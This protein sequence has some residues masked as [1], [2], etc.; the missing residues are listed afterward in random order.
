M[1][2][3]ASPQDGHR[4]TPLAPQAYFR[5]AGQI[6]ASDNNGLVRLRIPLFPLLKFFRGHCARWHDLIQDKDQREGRINPVADQVHSDL[7][8]MLFLQVQKCDEELRRFSSTIRIW[9]PDKDLRDHPL[10]AGHEDGLYGTDHMHFLPRDTQTKRR[11]RQ[12]WEEGSLTWVKH[13]PGGQDTVEA[14][15]ARARN[16]LRPNTFQHHSVRMT[17]TQSG[18]ANSTQP[19]RNGRQAL[20]GAIALGALFVGLQGKIGTLFGSPP[21][22]NHDL[23]VEHDIL[24]VLKIDDKR[25]KDMSN[26][27]SWIHDRVE[28]HTDDLL[29][30]TSTNALATYSDIFYARMQLITSGLRQL[31]HRNLD[32]GLVSPERLRTALWKLNGAMAI[33]GL[34]PIFNSELHLYELDIGHVASV[35]NLEV[36]IEVSVPAEPVNSRAKLFRFLPFPIRP[37]QNSSVWLEPWP[38]YEIIAVSLDGTRYTEIQESTLGRCRNIRGIFLCREAQIWMTFHRPSC[39]SSLF[40]QS[41]STILSA[42]RFAAVHEEERL[43]QVDARTFHLFSK[44]G[45]ILTTRCM[46]SPNKDVRNIQGMV[47]VSL[48][49]GCQAETPSFQFATTATVQQDLAMRH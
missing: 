34:Q 28:Q 18:V 29:T 32:P 41:G 43:I 2:A 47:A 22:A 9:F 7:R 21:R 25:L 31:L 16:R 45:T 14:V 37:S 38:R 11:D 3:S 4:I 46:G 23:T 12:P 10:L 8:S 6:A 35:Q 49:S 44:N 15:S 17:T 24:E 1:G 19:S 5:H 42:C 20:L 33:K 48:A 26:A 30:L 13:F 39:L 40:H 36:T 27:L